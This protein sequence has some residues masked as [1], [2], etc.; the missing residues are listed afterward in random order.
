MRCSVFILEIVQSG[1]GV[2]FAFIKKWDI[3]LLGGKILRT[4]EK[5]RFCI[6]VH[7]VCLL[8]GNLF[9]WSIICPLMVHYSLLL[10]G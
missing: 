1:T 8:L 9:L 5:K 7:V 10:G 6:H 2:P 3:G 4:S